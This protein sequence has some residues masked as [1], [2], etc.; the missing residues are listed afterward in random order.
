MLNCR[1]PPFQHVRPPPRDAVITHGAPFYAALV[2]VRGAAAALLARPVN[3]LLSAA[4]VIFELRRLPKTG[5]FVADGLPPKR[6]L[7]YEMFLLL[8][9]EVFEVLTDRNQLPNGEGK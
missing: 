8:F 7:R 4:T 3:F 1:H 5:Q 2:S 9:A 6:L